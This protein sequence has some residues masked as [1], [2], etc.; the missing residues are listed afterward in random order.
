MFF[1]KARRKIIRELRRNYNYYET[2]F[3]TSRTVSQNKELYIDVSGIV[4]NRYLYVFLKFF[5]LAGY[6][7]YLPKDKNIINEICQTKGEISR[8]LKEGFVKF[9][10]PRGDFDGIRISKN[11][12]SN[13]YFTTLLREKLM[14]E[15]SY[16]VPM[17]EYPSFYHSYENRKE[18][19]RN[20]T[21]KKSVF[22]SGNIDVRYYD[23][24]CKD[25]LFEIPSRRKVA[26]YIFQK[27][28]YLDIGC[29][30]DLENFIAS[31]LDNRVIIIDTVEK[32]R[33]SGSELKK[34][35]KSF[36]FF[37]A[38]PGIEAPLAHN[39]IEAMSTG[40]IPIIHSTYAG[41][42]RPVLKNN[43][44]AL[45]YNTLEE[46]VE[47]IESAFG[48][49]EEEISAL[50]D[51]VKRY[52]MDFLAPEAVVRKI[53]CNKY[54]KIFFFAETSSLS[55]LKKGLNKNG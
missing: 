51:N 33:I 15:D 49:S 27:E 40:S 9:G 5:H 44:N 54:S 35:I 2:I 53:E 31:E 24:I 37:L 42:F 50:R 39:L 14:K 45:V 4:L 3:I 20:I 25:G 8:I 26:D 16:H 17:C 7:V 22:M 34:V 23:K 19:S 21:R 18:C 43:K 29:P 55:Y 30:K 36:D 12:L 13:D 11:Q 52:Y 46:L 32:F 48:L 6:T 28:F 41:L 1:Y 47:V 38:L 10:S